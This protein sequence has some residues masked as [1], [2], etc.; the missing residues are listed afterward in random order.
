MLQL[1]NYHL[2]TTRIKNSSEDTD[3][4]VQQNYCYE[5]ISLLL[6]ESKAHEMQ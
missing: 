1:Q 2:D 6:D 3:W 5:E 4:R